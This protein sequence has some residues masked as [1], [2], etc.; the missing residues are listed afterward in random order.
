MKKL[1]LFLV[2]LLL[3]SFLMSSCQQNA[4]KPS[5]AVVPP[6]GTTVPANGTTALTDGEK[7]DPPNEP[8]ELSVPADKFQLELKELNIKIELPLAW[9]DRM[10][11]S[12]DGALAALTP[13]PEDYGVPEDLA[14]IYMEYVDEPDVF[15]NTFEKATSK[16]SLINMLILS[17]GQGDKLIERTPLEIKGRNALKVTYSTTSVGEPEEIRRAYLIDDGEGRFYF[18]KFIIEKEGLDGLSTFASEA[19]EA[20]TSLTFY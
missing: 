16:E 2:V 12:Q 9:K 17:E 11:I 5:E 1:R 18:I 7:T 14:Y 4:P 15:G 13:P 3:L 20:V 6:D 8:T 10:E 19:E